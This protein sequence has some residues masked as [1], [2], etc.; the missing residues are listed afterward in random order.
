MQHGYGFHHGLGSL[1]YQNHL[2][3]GGTSAQHDIYGADGYAGFGAYG[4]AKTYPGCPKATNHQKKIALNKTKRNALHKVL[5]AVRWKYHDE[6]IDYHRKQR[7]LDLIK[8]GYSEAQVQEEAAQEA[9]GGAGLRDPF[10]D[11]QSSVPIQQGQI[12]A[13]S[14]EMGVSST[15]QGPAIGKMILSL[16]ALSAFLFISYKGAERAGLIK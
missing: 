15:G 9:G 5:N 8:C 2:L 3:A 10:V 1:W 7:D 4:A 14:P 16:S 6:L 12:V 13:A 11:A